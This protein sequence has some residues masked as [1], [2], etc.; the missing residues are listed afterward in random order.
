MMLLWQQQCCLI[1]RWEMELATSKELANKGSE[2]DGSG[3]T[4]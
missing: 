4:L 2:L 1:S 3:R